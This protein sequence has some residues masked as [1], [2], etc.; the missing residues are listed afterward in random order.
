MK[1]ELEIVLKSSASCSPSPS[2][3][4]MPSTMKNN[5]K[6]S[7]VRLERLRKAVSKVLK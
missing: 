4:S 5:L 7:D 2:Y 6:R 1:G 3:S